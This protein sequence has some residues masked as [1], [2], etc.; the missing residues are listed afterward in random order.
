M[1][2][3]ETTR[4]AVAL[5]QVERVVRAATLKDLPGSPANVLGLLDLY[6]V[7]VPIISLRRRLKLPDREIETSDEII[8]LNRH[9]TLLGLLVDEVEDV[10][11]IKQIPEIASAAEIKHLSGALKLGN[12][13]VLV[14]DID[15]FLTQE[16]EL[17]LVLSMMK[18]RN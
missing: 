3:V 16:D 9:G 6:G 10:V 15:R 14:H 7:P 8:I 4:L 5:E 12:D 1:F 2:T 11:Q 18:Q 17:E 13:I